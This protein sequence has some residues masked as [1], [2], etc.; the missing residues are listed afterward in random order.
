MLCT[1]RDW[2]HGSF[3]LYGKAYRYLYLHYP[4]FP[5]SLGFALRLLD[6]SNSP[7]AFT[8]LYLYNPSRPLQGATFPHCSSSTQSTLQE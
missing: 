7:P 8:L 5:P 6:Y 2:P 3:L 1:C 4:Q